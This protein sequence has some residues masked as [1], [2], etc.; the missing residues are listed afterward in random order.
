LVKVLQKLFWFLLKNISEI[1]MINI[2]FFF[3]QKSNLSEKKIKK[4]KKLKNILKFL[5]KRVL[6]KKKK[7][8]LEI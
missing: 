6:I 4:L 1:N 2:L 5:K 8:S 3:K 7:I